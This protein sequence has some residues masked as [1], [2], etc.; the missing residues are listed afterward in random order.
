MTDRERIIVAVA[1]ML[2]TVAL[3][4]PPLWTG[5]VTIS[6]GSSARTYL[7]RERPRAFWTAW[8]FYALLALFLYVKALYPLFPP[9]KP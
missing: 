3:V 5:R 8:S 9:R 6:R 4:L 1:G 2:V 7:R